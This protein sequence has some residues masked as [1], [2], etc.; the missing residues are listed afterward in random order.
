MVGYDD[1]FRA[2]T[3][4]FPCDDVR[5]TVYRGWVKFDLS[6]FDSLGV[7][8]LL[9]DLES[10]GTRVDGRA[11]KSSP[12]NSVATVL[13]VATQSFSP[14]LPYDNAA[15]LPAGVN[16]NVGVGGQVRDWVSGS[17]PNFGFVIDTS[18]DRFNASYH[19]KDNELQVSWYTNFRLRVVYN[20]ALNPRAPQ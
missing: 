19:P 11:V 12:G 16:I 17:R 5:F 14:E 4:P 18:R 8:S 10:F 3:D 13:G 20:P 15:S 2:G 6:Q 9:F 7:A 1:Y